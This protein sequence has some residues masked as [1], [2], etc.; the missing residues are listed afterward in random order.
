MLKSSVFTSGVDS[1][2]EEREAWQKY[3][4]ACEVCKESNDASRLKDSI[5]S[6][7]P[8]PSVML[9]PLGSNHCITGEFVSPLTFLD[10]IHPTLYDS[11][12][13]AM[14]VLLTERESAD[15]GTACAE[16]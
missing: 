7:M 3:R 11:P 12:S 1:A 5:V 15:W 9:L 16:R 6:V 2:G 10:A 4:P 8:S 14:C 13:K